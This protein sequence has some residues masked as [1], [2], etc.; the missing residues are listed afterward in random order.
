MCLFCLTL[1]LVLGYAG[2]LVY[3]S[4]SEYSLQKKLNALEY[5]SEAWILEAARQA[6]QGYAH[7]QHDLGRL[8]L[9]YYTGMNGET[10]GTVNLEEGVKWIRKAAEQGGS[11]CTIRF[12]PLLFHG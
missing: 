9:G 4:A 7:A 11:F 10:Y 5:G 3:S 8:Y 1:S 6:E 12:K 2:Y